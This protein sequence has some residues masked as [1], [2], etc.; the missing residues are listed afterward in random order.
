MSNANPKCMLGVNYWP[1]RKAMYW[2][3]D[4]DVGETR[5][6]FSEIASWGLDLVRIMLMWETF[7]PEPF[8]MSE[9]ALRHL[10]M[11]LDVAQEYRLEV[12]PTL[13][14]GHM[15]GINW[16]PSWALGSS[17]RP[18]DIPTWAGGQPVPRI[19]ANLYE[20]AALLRAQCF[21]VRGVVGR[22][23]QHP[24]IYAW[25]ITNEH[26]NLLTPATPDAAWLWNRLLCDEV[27]RLDPTHPVTAGLH[28]ED[29]D[30]FRNFRSVD[31]ADG[32]D[33]LSIHGYALYTRWARTQ[34]DAA[35]V[36]FGVALA[37]ALG[38]KPVMA[39]EYGIC[40]TV[41]G[42][43][44]ALE[45]TRLGTRTW[46]QFYASDAEAAEYYRAVGQGVLE[47]GAIGA[48]AWCFSDYDP[49]LYDRPPFDVLPHERWFG[50]TRASGELK[51]CGHAFL[52]LRGQSVR[53][54][55]L[56]EVPAHY[57]DDPEACFRQLFE[58]YAQHAPAPPVL[59]AD[60]LLRIASPA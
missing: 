23:A 45:M 10:G 25:N 4:F 14:V 46:K 39:E 58:D 12:I 29:F 36:P 11:V 3:D 24:A 1:R 22:F 27:R 21:G 37:R 48:V 30:R 5:Q 15:S 44:S 41:D 59:A 19:A 9:S 52:E 47:A 13:F 2:W 26:D 40:T 31:M 42:R 54:A 34:R 18:E 43:T 50:L 32:N 51:P 55:P 17:A 7:Q 60:P 56:L 28:I 8:T 20:D 6:E 49:A 35:V 57:Y 53:S 16:L 33:Y 38:R